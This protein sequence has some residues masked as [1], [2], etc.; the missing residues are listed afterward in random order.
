VAVADKLVATDRQTVTATITYEMSTANFAVA[1]WQAFLSEPPELP[2]QTKVQ[3]TA[4]PG[5]RV[6]TE[7]SLLARKV[8]FVDVPVAPPAPGAKLTIKQEIRAT[9]RAR[10]LVPLGPDEKPPQVA[11]LTAAERKYYLSPTGLIDH[12]SVP[13]RRWLDANKLR[14][15]KDE[16]AT[17]FAARVLEVIRANFAYHYDPDEDKRASLAC[18]RDKTDCGGMSYLFVAAMRASD[19][20][21]RVLVGRTAR[22]REPGADRSQLGY[23]R[24]HVRAE[25][26]AAGVGWVPVD[27]AFANGNKNRPVRDF[28]G[29]DEGDLLVLHVDVDLQLPYPDKVREARVL[30]TAPHYWVFG[31]GAFDGTFGPSGWE[32]KAEPVGKK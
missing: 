4:T 28:V 8:R 16:S 2:S 18:G 24:P 20:P 31:K 25:L 29:N 11:P 13:V 26:Y 14:K 9:L 12:D 32:L 27:P 1:R 7:K 21:A 15:G 5:G 17:D 22:A 23:D 19:V 10:K 6:L 3:V 30:Q